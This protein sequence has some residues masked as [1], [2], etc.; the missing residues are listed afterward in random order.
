[1]AIED[2]NEIERVLVRRAK[3]K[4]ILQARRR[5]IAQAIDQE[6]QVTVY[7]LATQRYHR[8]WPVDAAELIARGTAVLKG[9]EPQPD[10]APIPASESP[11]AEPPAPVAPAS[12]ANIVPS[13]GTKGR[14]KHAGIKPEG[15]A[16]PDS[17][18][19]T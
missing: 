18:P 4:A 9:S 12:G 2:P 8:V 7:E 13:K 14:G 1:M 5:H 11:P 15:P 6:G 3:Q 10:P 16:I 19:P 17:A